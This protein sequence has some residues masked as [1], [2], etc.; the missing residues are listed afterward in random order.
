MYNVFRKIWFCY[1]IT[2]DLTSF[3]KLIYNTKKYQWSKGKTLK[4]ELALP[5]ERYFLKSSGKNQPVYLRTFAGDLDILYEI[6]FENIYEVNRFIN[7]EPKVIIDLGAHV[8]IASL[9]FASKYPAAEFFCLEP[10]KENFELLSANLSPQIM[11][12]RAHIYNAAAM[13]EDGKVFVQTGLRRYNSKVTPAVFETNTQAISINTVL[14]RNGLTEITMMKIDIEGSEKFLFAENTQWLS[15]TKNIIFKFHS[16][17]DLKVVSD[18]LRQYDFRV[19]I[20]QG[21]D[22]APHILT[23]AKLDSE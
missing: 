16:P 10:D 12:A 14:K 6:F 1:K 3:F 19:N 4:A 5:A 20:L 7:R 23:A 2:G 18:K 13:P 22:S 11:K 15:V 9:Y 21:T 17:E 8:G